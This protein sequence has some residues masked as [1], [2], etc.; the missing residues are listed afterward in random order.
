MNSGNPT[1]RD[2][3]LTKTI[4]LKSPPTLNK[5]ASDYSETTLRT[6]MNQKEKN[7]LETNLVYESIPEEIIQ[8]KSFSE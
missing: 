2:D 1:D 5:Y 4:Q 3:N 7:S 6:T 8:R